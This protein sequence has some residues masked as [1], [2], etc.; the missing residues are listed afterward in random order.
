MNSKWTS[1]SLSELADIKHGWAFKSKYFSELST[2][3]PLVIGVGNFRYEGGFRFDETKVKF[4]EGDFPEEYILCSEDILLIMTCQTAGGEILGIPAKV[5]NDER[6][7]L[8]NQRLGKFINNRTDIF[9]SEYAYNVF[10]SKS[11]NQFLFATSTGTKILHTSPERIL[12]YSFQ[13]PPLSDQKAIAHI[14]KTL[15]NKIEL[16]KK[17]YKNL[18]EIAKALFKSWFIDF[19]PVKAKAEGYATRFEDEISNL[20]PNSFED[21]EIGKIPKNW[22]I[23][24]LDEIAIYLNGLA[25][26]KYPAK[27]D[28]S[29]LPVIKIAQLRKGNSKESDKC[30]SN[31]E[32]KYIIRDGDVLFSWSGSLFVDLWTGGIGALNQHLFKVTSNIYNK[33]FTLYWTKYHLQEFQRIAKSKATTMGHI[34]RKHLS[35]A[36]I[37]LPPKNLMKEINSIFDPLVERQISVRLESKF[38]FQLRDILLP[39]LLSGELRIPDAEKMLEDI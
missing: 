31:I 28:S 19:D 13:L 33:W 29:D 11:F 15:D 36:K 25:L 7:Y 8:H 4:Y 5:P 22:E 16:N 30:S 12:D 6:L 3:K 14:L 32:E 21:S 9:D 18:E 17:T 35:E 23:R 2:N 24:S 38:L 27:G 39:N 26:Q 34:Q 37:I 20:F 10:L 1:I